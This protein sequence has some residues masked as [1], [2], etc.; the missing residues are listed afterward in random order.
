[1]INGIAYDWESID[2]FVVPMGTSVSI[3]EITYEDNRKIENIYGKG[4]IAR[5]KGRG[6]YEASMNFSIDREEYALLQLLL[7]GSVYNQTFFVIVNYAND[8]QPTFTDIIND[9]DIT[10]Q[11]TSAK[12]GDKE[13]GRMK[14]DC[15]VGSPILWNGLPAIF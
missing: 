1:M 6:N 4:P 2:I 3:T 11:A 7:G 15:N 10:K 5:K 12:Q 14:L 8:G 9:V 13:V